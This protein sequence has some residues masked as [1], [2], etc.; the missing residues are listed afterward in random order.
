ME[1]KSQ[2]EGEKRKEGRKGKKQ[3][4]RMMEKEGGWKKLRKYNIQNNSVI[5]KVIKEEKIK[6]YRKRGRKNKQRKEE[7]T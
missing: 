6:Q 2:V 4:K 3:T 7:W 5:N 1:S